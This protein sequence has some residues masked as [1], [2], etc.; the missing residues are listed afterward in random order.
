MSSSIAHGCGRSRFV[1]RTCCLCL[2]PRWSTGPTRQPNSLAVNDSCP[3]PLKISTIVNRLASRRRTSR[4]SGPS[5]LATGLAGPA[6]APASPPGN[7]AGPAA[8][9]LTAV[10]TLKLPLLPPA[11]GSSAAHFLLLAVPSAPP[12]PPAD[13]GA[14]RSL[15]SWPAPRSSECGQDFAP[16]DG[17]STKAWSLARQPPH[18]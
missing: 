18:T 8:G 2:L 9:Q 7:V 1:A 16:A 12:S 6:T 3:E 13:G 10:P 5:R 14:S 17:Q 4:S 11:S 15:A